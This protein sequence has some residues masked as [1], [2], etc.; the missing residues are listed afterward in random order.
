M[1]AAYTLGDLDS[2]YTDLVAD[3]L[4][5]KN[6]HRR[7]DLMGNL[8]VVEVVVAHTLGDLD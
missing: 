8:L 2:L 5:R 7:A 6:F 1:V 3:Y 4:I